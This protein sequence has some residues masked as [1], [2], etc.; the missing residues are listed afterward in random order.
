MRCYIF[1]LFVIGY[2]SLATPVQ[3]EKILR[4][5]DQNGVTHYADNPPAGETS[6]EEVHIQPTN[7]VDVPTKVLS[8]SIQA[9]FA[10]IEQNRSS[11]TRSGFVIKGPPKKVL[12]PMA[13]PS[14]KRLNGRYRGRVR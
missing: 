11:E 3:A 5:L 9:A 1:S 6:V 7:K 13:R 10:A 4:W 12:T 14:S 2:L 8:P